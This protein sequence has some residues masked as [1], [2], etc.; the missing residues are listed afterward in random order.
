MEGVIGIK[1]II[2]NIDVSHK[3]KI[4]LVLEDGRQIYVPVSFF[5][6]IKKLSEL[7]RQKWNIIDDVMFTFK[8]CDEV[9][10]IEQVLGMEKDYSYLN[11]R[12][13]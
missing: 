1:P 5:P 6:S 4:G 11:T 12:G 8:N 7:E 9:F 13:Y 2:K 3:G 10:H